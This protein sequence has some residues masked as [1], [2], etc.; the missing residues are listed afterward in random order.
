VLKAANAKGEPVAIKKMKKKYYSWSEC[1]NLREVQSLK[2]LKHPN[3]VQLKEVIRENDEL[4]FVFEFCEEGN[5]YTYC[6]GRKKFL[7]E[8]RIQSI[9]YQ[10]LAGLAYCHRQ[11]YFHR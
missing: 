11:G 1:V 3:I 5:L 2:K 8:S 7:P 9:M 6:K 4:F 10:L